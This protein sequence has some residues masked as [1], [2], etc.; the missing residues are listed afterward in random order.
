MIFMLLKPIKEIKK[1]ILT[2]NQLMEKHYHISLTLKQITFITLC[3]S[4][5]V[6]LGSL[7]LTAFSRISM[8]VFQ[9]AALSW[10]LHN[11]KIPWSKLLRSA[12]ITIF[13]LYGITCVHLLIDDTDRQR[14]KVVKVLFRVFKTIDKKTGGYMNAQNIVLVAIVTDKYTIPFFFTF[15]QPDP[16]YAVWEKNDKK[17]RKQKIPKS[18]RPKEPNRNPNYPTRIEI[19]MNLLMRA[20][21][22]FISLK[23][24]EGLE[25]EVVSISF[26]SAFLSPRIRKFVKKIFPKTQCISQIAK[27]QLVSSKK[28]KGKSTLNYFI[29]KKTI[30]KHLNIR[31]NYIQIEFASARLY[32]HSHKCKLNVVA[33]KYNGEENFRYIVA[34]NLDWTAETI[35]RAYALR[36]LIE[37]V[38]FDWK[39]YDGWGRKAFQRGGDGA[40]RGVILS[41]LVDLFLLQHPHQVQRI[42]SGQ[43]LCTAG[44]L[45]RRIQNDN[46]MET[47]KGVIESA[48]PKEKLK[49]I[50]ELAEDLYFLEVS[51]K[52]MAGVKLGDLGSSKGLA[53]FASR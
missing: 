13:K 46:F 37:V 29:N 10:M 26:D 35:I 33:I 49:Q 21:S 39:Q 28:E 40:C 12:L 51:K 5:M 4:G 18:K 3:M 7:N 6:L 8:G 38:N 43:P 48:N 20:N 16:V 2:T 15:Y 34:S 45:T 30:S 53:R 24:L 44:S 22:F 32:V 23:D 25:I 27:N 47:I 19:A 36:W 14:S 42:N 9:P 1:F 41:L 52:H 17:L 50:V 11:S 31:G